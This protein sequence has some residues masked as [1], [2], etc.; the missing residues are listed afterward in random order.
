MC[1]NCT[2]VPYNELIPFTKA[3][4]IGELYNVRGTLC[5]GLNDEEKVSGVYH[6]IKQMLPCLARY[7]MM[8]E[9]KYELLWFNGQPFIFYISIGGAHFRKED[10]ACS[11]LVSFPDIGRAILSGNE[12][13]LL[14]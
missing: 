2:K 3:I 13:F 5:K 10:S 9:R 7:Y 1:N 8:N 11:W 12:N 6:N 14:F 4:D